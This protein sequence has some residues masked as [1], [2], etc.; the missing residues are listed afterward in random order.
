MRTIIIGTLFF[1]CG[2]FVK[3]IPSEAIDW[4]EQ[5]YIF[6]GCILIGICICVG[7]QG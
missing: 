1:I 5:H 6:V 3:H 2:I 7:A 4:V